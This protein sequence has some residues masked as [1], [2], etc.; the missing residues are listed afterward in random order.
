MDLDTMADQV[1]D[2]F[3]RD[4]YRHPENRITERKVARGVVL[5]AFGAHEQ[6]FFG[7]FL[8][9][10]PWAIP[11]LRRFKRWVESLS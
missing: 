8:V 3:V 7:E 4:S 11:I 1:A 6:R 9:Q 10:W 5:D 2:Q